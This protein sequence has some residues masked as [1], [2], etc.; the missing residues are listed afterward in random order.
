MRTRWLLTGCTVLVASIAAWV[1]PE[2][3]CACS[4]AF[5]PAVAGSLPSDGATDVPLDTSPVIVGSVSSL[6]VTTADGEAVPHVLTRFN[7]AVGVEFSEPLLPDTTYV[8]HVAPEFELGESAALTF[9]TGQSELSAMVP[10]VEDAIVSALTTEL[11]GYWVYLCSS[12]SDYVCVSTDIPEGFALV[13]DTSFSSGPERHILTRGLDGRYMTYGWYSGTEGAA[14]GFLG[15]GWE[16][17]SCVSLALRD[18]AGTEGPRLELCG[19]DIT[20]FAPATLSSISCSGGMIEYTGAETLPE[21]AAGAANGPDD[22]VPFPEPSPDGAGGGAPEPAE[23][24]PGPS[25]HPEATDG[26][27]E[28]PRP[29]VP[30]EPSSGLRPVDTTPRSV[31]CNIHAPRADRALLPAALGLLVFAWRSR[32]AISRVGAARRAA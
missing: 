31:G 21:G 12:P 16:Q 6:E 28:T 32:R 29:E 1:V 25:V 30:E 13:V 8:I 3:A 7:Q 4:L 23:P 5:P 24:P 17:E 2:P 18:A 10:P 9:T 20:R 19:D 11:P 14:T 22:P 15:A 26:G 27:S